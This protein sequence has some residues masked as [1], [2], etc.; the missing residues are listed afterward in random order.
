MI[1]TS[2]SM[3]L[4]VSCWFEWYVDLFDRLPYHVQIYNRF[5]F[6]ECK[7][8]VNRLFTSEADNSFQE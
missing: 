4:K 6:L 8:S 3:L 2:K 7:P 5:I 1:N